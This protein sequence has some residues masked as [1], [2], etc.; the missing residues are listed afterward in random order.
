ML[1]FLSDVNDNAPMLRPS[2]QHLEV[3]QSAGDKALLIEAEDSD[4]EPYSDPFTFRL[5]STRGDTGDMWR[6]GENRGAYHT[7][8]R[9]RLEKDRELT[10]TDS[11][12]EECASLCHQERDR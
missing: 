1:L 12:Q 3:C 2:S 5:D 8:Q 11:G 7:G 4:L 6:L 9:E 10:H